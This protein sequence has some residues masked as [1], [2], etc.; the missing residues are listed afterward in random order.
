MEFAQKRSMWSCHLKSMSER[1]ERRRRTYPV[2]DL[3][4]A[5]W[6]VNAVA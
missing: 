4:M 3:T 6:I 2:L 1:V 5:D